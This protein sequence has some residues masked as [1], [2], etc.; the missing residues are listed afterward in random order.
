MTPNTNIP[1]YYVEPSRGRSSRAAR[2]KLH[3]QKCGSGLFLPN[4]ETFLDEDHTEVT[5]V[6]LSSVILDG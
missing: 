1:N 2:E 3:T 6:T 5:Y 4:M